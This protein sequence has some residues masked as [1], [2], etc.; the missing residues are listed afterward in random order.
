M[1]WGRAGL[2]FIRHRENITRLLRGEEP[3][4]GGGAPAPTA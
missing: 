1:A 2:I 3:R 4:I